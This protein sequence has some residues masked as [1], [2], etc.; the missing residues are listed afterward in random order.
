MGYVSEERKDETH[1]ALNGGPGSTRRR[2]EIVLKN[3]IQA[4]GLVFYSPLFSV[5][6][7]FATR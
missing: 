4:R 5:A 2:E 3:L 1:C 7:V 6:K